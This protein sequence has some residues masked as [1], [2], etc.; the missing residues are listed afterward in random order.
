ML[1]CASVQTISHV[2]AAAWQHVGHLAGNKYICT[3]GMLQA[4][5]S[6]DSVC[7]GCGGQP[8]T[9]PRP[10]HQA[11]DSADVHQAVLAIAAKFP[12][13]P[14]FIVGFSLGAYTVNTYIGERDTGRFGPGAP[15]TCT[16]SAFF[17][18]GPDIRQW[19]T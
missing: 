15:S 19:L 9:S 13:A 6:C 12:E 11:R 4:N 3:W 16:S 1:A 5:L 10:F 2:Q 14:V 18:R 8:L 7:R 17:C